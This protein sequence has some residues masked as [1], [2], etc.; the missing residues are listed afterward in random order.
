[1]EALRD[2]RQAGRV[3]V[4]AVLLIMLS[5]AALGG[6]WLLSENLGRA[7]GQWRERVRLVVYLAE[8]PAPRHLNDFLGKIESVE[9]VQRVRFVS[10]AEA[11]RSLRQVLGTQAGVTDQLPR[12]PLPA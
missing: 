12:N 6:F 9:G 11:L 1:M 2:I 10:K 5:L 7:I 3:G 8:E 4:S